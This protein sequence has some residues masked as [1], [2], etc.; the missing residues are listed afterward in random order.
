MLAW[1]QA[2]D[3][4]AIVF[5]FQ[6]RGQEEA[7]VLGA[8]GVEQ[9]H[10]LDLAETHDP[11]LLCRLGQDRDE[12]MVEVL[13]V[14]LGVQAQQQPAH[15]I[16]LF[17]QQPDAA[18]AQAGQQIAQAA[19]RGYAHGAA[20]QPFLQGLGRSELHAQ[21]LAAGIVEDGEALEHVVHG[22]HVE[23]ELHGVAGEP[24]PALKK[25]DAMFVERQLGN[26]NLRQHRPSGLNC[27]GAD[28]LAR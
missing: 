21:H 15:F 13:G 20:A 26:G 8:L 10:T 14:G 22:V 27:L 5:L 4:L 11:H 25:A 3:D 2:H 24:G 18:P 6:I 17:Q 1:G 16:C 12:H 23:G 7:Q 28:W 9:F 19:T